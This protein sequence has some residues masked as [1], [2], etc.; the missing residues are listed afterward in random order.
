MVSKFTSFVAVEHREKVI[1]D[2]Y[3]ELFLTL[4]KSSTVEKWKNAK[5]GP[6]QIWTYEFLPSLLQDEKF[7]EGLGPSI[8]DL[9]GAEEVDILQYI[10]WEQKPDME[11]TREPVRQNI[12]C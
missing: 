12:I 6:T 4:V 7:E 3:F 5:N 10:G 2:R 11:K 8:Y 1:F 9:V